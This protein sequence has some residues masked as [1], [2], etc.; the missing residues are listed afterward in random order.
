MSVVIDSNLLVRTATNAADGAVISRQLLDWRR[1]GETLHA[2]WLLR[3]EV[4][5]AL[6]RYVAM[7]ELSRE[8]AEAAWEQIERLGRSIVFHDIADGA[9]VI[10][11][12]QTLKRKNAYDAAY[13]ALAEELH[14][15]VWTI[16]GPLAR[17]AAE[18]GLPVK[19]IELPGT[20]S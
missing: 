3:Y 9:R 6:A 7:G 15:D 16:D 5:N 8:D 11:I 4:A 10:A 13:I 14:T 12:T 18:T 1:A 17:N 2:P 20:A 19:L